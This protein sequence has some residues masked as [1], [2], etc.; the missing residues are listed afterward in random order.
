LLGDRAAGDALSDPQ[1]DL[2]HHLRRQVEARRRDEIA[3]R[4]VERH[5][6]ARLHT[7]D[8]PRLVQDDLDRPVDVEAGGDGA[9]RLDERA[10]LPRPALALREELGVVDGDPRLIREGLEQVLVM[11]R[12]RGGPRRERREDADEA[13]PDLEGHAEHRADALELVDVA[14]GGAGI[15]ADVV[16]ADGHAALGTAPDQPL[17]ERHREDAPRVGLEAVSGGVHEVAAFVVEQPDAAA[18]AADECRHRAAD[19]LEHGGQLESRGD[20]P[21]RP[22][23]SRQLLGA[24]PALVQQP[25]LLDRGSQRTGQVE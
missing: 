12:E 6:A 19:R 16:D 17:A 18:R 21:A 14:P 1:A 22:V 11:G 4:G 20:E 15:D 8:D 2:R 7:E 9:S 3:R 5:E 23:E 13:A 25:P 10:R 24:A